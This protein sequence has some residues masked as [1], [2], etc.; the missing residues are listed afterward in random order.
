MG[1]FVVEG[2]VSLTSC[3][4]MVDEGKGRLWRAGVDK[5]AVAW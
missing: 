5:L 4:L 1:E 2:L 3:S